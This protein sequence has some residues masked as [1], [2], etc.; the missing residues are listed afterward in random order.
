MSTTTVDQH[1]Q[2][3]PGFNRFYTHQIG[4]P[5]SMSTF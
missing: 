4:V 5:C 3:V 1:A 2:T